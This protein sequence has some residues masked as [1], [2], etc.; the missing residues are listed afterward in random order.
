MWVTLIARLTSCIFSPVSRVHAVSVTKGTAVW[1][2]G[3]LGGSCSGTP[4][5]SGDDD[6][7]FLTHN[8]ASSSNF[9]ILDATDGSIFYREAVSSSLLLSPPGIYVN[10]LGGNY[11]T[12]AGN[13]NDLIVFGN[14][15]A[16]DATSVVETSS[17]YAFQF[18]IGFPGSTGSSLGVVELF[19]D[20]NFES[21]T[22]PVITNSGSSMFWGVSRSTIKGWSSVTFD[23]DPG[24]NSIGF[25]RGDPASRPI[26]AELA[27]GVDKVTPTL[28]SGT[29]GN[30]FA[31]VSTTA[32]STTGSATMAALWQVGTDSPVYTQGK[33]APSTADEVVFFFEQFGVGYAVDAVNGTVLWTREIDTTALVLGNFAINA[34]GDTIYVADNSGVLAAWQVAEFGA[35]KTFAPSAAPVDSAAPVVSGSPVDT[36]V[37][38]PTDSKAPTSSAPAVP[39]KPTRTSSPVTSTPT[40]KATSP[41]SPQPTTQAPTSAAPAF[42][43]VIAAASSAIVLMM[44]V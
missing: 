5:V 29:A 32:T 38:A 20:C 35:N 24:G 15:P 13:T 10:P 7:V 40:V 30:A 12:G 36:N 41:V 33:V 42:A 34:A 37:S 2:S 25:D 16:A 19:G 26:I 22:P 6:Y 4:V 8:S 17:F 39:T 21:T 27:I 3:S 14:R 11:A 1:V 28:Y 18:P 43:G 9:T 23:R 44:L 31:A